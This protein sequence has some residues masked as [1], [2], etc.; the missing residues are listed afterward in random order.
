M[1][2]R[3]TNY[4][5]TDKELLAIRYYVEYFRHYLLGRPFIVRSDHRPLKFLF[6]LKSPSGR[7][8]IWP[9]ILSGYDFEVH[10]RQGARHGNADGMSSGRNPKDCSCPDTDMGESLKCG[11]C[12]TCL[13]RAEQI[14]STMLKEKLNETEGE[15]F[16]QH[17][18]SRYVNDRS[19]TESVRKGL[20]KFTCSCV[21]HV[22]ICFINLIL[23]FPGTNCNILSLD[24]VTLY[25]SACCALVA[26]AK[27]RLLHNV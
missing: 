13:K 12:K 15:E 22:G 11:P 5:A 27:N 14:E 7:I 1:N 25:S 2:K 10:Y 19:L 8:A 18:V 9:E 21:K 24:K 20:W 3:E 23:L 26:T 17:Q 16:V 4:C 6:S